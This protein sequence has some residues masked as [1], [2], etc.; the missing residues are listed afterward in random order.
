MK[1][2]KISAVQNQ[3]GFN[4]NFPR[5]KQNATRFCKYCRRS[6]HTIAFCR[7]KKANDFQRQRSRQPPPPNAAFPYRGSR[8]YSNPHWQRRSPGPSR[9]W[10]NSE[11]E[12][13][14]SKNMA[15]AKR[16]SNLGAMKMLENQQRQRISGRSPSPNFGS[17]RVRFIEENDISAIDNVT[18][19]MP[20]N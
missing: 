1:E 20:L 14:I 18:A 16:L 6:G 17:S 8:P 7:A 10:P 19:E 2:N 3:R 12:D 15:E 9:S 11:T 4:P 5:M 13:Q